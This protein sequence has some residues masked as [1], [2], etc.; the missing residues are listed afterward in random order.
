MPA[1]AKI[2]IPLR[3]EFRYFH[4]P[5][6]GAPSDERAVGRNQLVQEFADR[7]VMS[8]GGAFL[9]GGLRGVGKTTFVKLAMQRVGSSRGR[10]PGGAG[11]FELVDVW[12]NLSRAIEPVQLLH[13]LIR[14]LYLRLKQVKLLDR[15][16]EELRNDLRRAF[17]RTSFE[18]S[19]RAQDQEERGRSSEVGFG[20][21]P[22]IG[23]EFLGKMSASYKSSRTDEEALKYLPYDEKAAEFDIADFAQRLQDGTAALRR[24][25]WWQRMLRPFRGAPLAPPRVRVVFV[26]DE[27]DKL[28]RQA[29]GRQALERQG[30]E[31]QGLERPGEAAAETEKAAGG[32]G[33]GVS[34][35]DPILQALKTVFSASGVSFV[36][37][38]GKEVE[39]RLIEDISHA[40]SI[41]ESIFAY[42]LYLPCLWDDQG[43]ILKQYMSP[44]KEG[45]AD[46]Y[47]ESYRETVARYLRYKGRGI[48][49]RTWREVNKYVWWEADGPKLILDVKSRRYM[50]LFSKLEEGLQD[51]KLFKAMEDNA[52]NV[53]RDR[54]KLYFYYTADWVLGRGAETFTPDDVVA[55]AQT[56]NLGGKLTPTAASAIAQ[57]TLDILK[58]RACIEVDSGR[59]VRGDAPWKDVYY[60][61]CPWVLR[62]FEGSAE[63]ETKAA[64][65]PIQDE[66]LTRLG[67]YQVLD[68]IGGGATSQIF[69][70]RGSGGEIRAAKVMRTEQTQNAMMAAL[71]RDE[72][73]MLREFDDSGIVKVFDSGE[74]NGRSYLVMEL[75]EG[76][77]LDTLIRSVKVLPVGTACYVAAQLAE[78]LARIHAKGW[79]HRDVKPGNIFVTFGG[80]TK[81]MDFGIAHRRRDWPER[82]TAFVLGTPGYMAP[83]QVL[84]PGQATETNDVYSLAVT[85]FEMI[86]GQLPFGSSQQI[87]DWKGLQEEAPSLLQFV[88]APEPLAEILGE[89][90]AKSSERRTQTMQAFRAALLPW[91]DNSS[92]GLKAAVAACRETAQ[93]SRKITIAEE[94]PAESFMRV[95]I[96][97]AARNW[98]AVSE[99]AESSAE[100]QPALTTDMEK[101]SEIVS[102]DIPVTV[103]R[104][105]SDLPAF[106][107]RLS[108]GMA[109][110]GGMAAVYPGQWD[111]GILDWPAIRD[112]FLPG[113]ALKITLERICEEPK[114]LHLLVDFLDGLC[115]WGGP[116]AIYRSIQIREGRLILGRSASEVDLPLDVPEISRQQVAF[117]LSAENE[118]TIWAEDL[119]S[120]NGTRVN[121][122]RLSRRQLD[123]GDRVQFGSHEILIHRIPANAEDWAYPPHSGYA[124]TSRVEASGSAEAGPSIA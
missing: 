121:G 56:L 19:S 85:L 65:A 62:A 124:Q 8:R 94:V 93:Q 18:I 61:L 109:A 49:R 82:T 86:T 79:I 113:S 58:N 70:V 52:D 1:D 24:E 2:R 14:H 48:P 42:N 26:L 81:L 15:L 63:E 16:D 87:Q 31:R 80:R 54:Q 98:V 30:L 27:L 22:F 96:P 34:V 4:E 36:F 40:D 71:F 122:E 12:L 39:E 76:V 103:E 57:T 102:A 104:P 108:E 33:D 50:D 111:G 106:L 116:K 17:M 120:R 67:T 46:A 83:E 105:R 37:V 32:P 84:N 45:E 118:G 75:L 10:Y 66:G 119:S 115:L 44:V 114:I 97:P 95:A 38:G 99:A 69:K 91:Q 29:P 112:A 100:I 35:L 88:K 55:M 25:S 3:E 23:I 28:E 21:A 6:S 64:V 51:D 73:A 72:I 68:E 5:V 20:K 43:G 101:A 110:A 89:A 90:L 78:T 123:E 13:L 9:V 47:T 60:K 117:T 74:Q 107:P 59:T 92:L 7:I 41:Y 53:R 77:A 11:D